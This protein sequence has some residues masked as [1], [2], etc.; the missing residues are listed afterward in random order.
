MERHIQYRQALLK[1]RDCIEDALCDNDKTTHLIL[2]KETALEALWP[3]SNKALK[4]HAK[5]GFT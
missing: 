5:R 2:I 4:T 3:Q 1:I